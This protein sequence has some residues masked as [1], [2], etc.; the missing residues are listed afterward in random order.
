MA[1]EPRHDASQKR[2]VSV[3]N[4]SLG[5]NF[6]APSSGDDYQLSRFSS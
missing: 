3:G 4:S 2:P 5:G 6:N 1:G